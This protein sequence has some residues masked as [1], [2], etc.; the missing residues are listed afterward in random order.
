MGQ[1]IQEAVGVGNELEGNAEEQDRGDELPVFVP[2]QHPQHPA[3]HHDKKDREK[4]LSKR[5]TKLSIGVL[6]THL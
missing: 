4:M 5:W 3:A 2:V 6:A 1:D